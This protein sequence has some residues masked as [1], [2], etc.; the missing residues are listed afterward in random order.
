VTLPRFCRNCGR[1]LPVGSVSYHIRIEMWAAPDIAV[2]SGE[3]PGTKSLEDLIA[4]LE[5]MSDSEAEEAQAQVHEAHE[6]RICPRCRRA[7]RNG[8]LGKSGD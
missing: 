3:H 7:I 4:Q 2:Q 8:L 1:S 6:F 5:Q